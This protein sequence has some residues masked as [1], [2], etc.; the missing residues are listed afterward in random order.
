MVILNKPDSVIN[1]NSRW[2][3]LMNCQHKG[4]LSLS[5]FFSTWPHSP[6]GTGS[7]D[8]LIPAPHRKC[9]E[10]ESLDLAKELSGPW[11]S[12]N[13][14]SVQ[15][16]PGISWQ[17]A[18]LGHKHHLLPSADPS[19]CRLANTGTVSHSHHIRWKHDMLN[20]EYLASIRG[21]RC[22]LSALD[23]KS[24]AAAFLSSIP[25]WSLWAPPTSQIFSF[26]FWISCSNL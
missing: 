17:R 13:D 26:S 22:G 15:Y 6:G 14:P 21:I 25:A 10:Q 1:L 8:C 4:L 7:P 12:S 11:C 5:L 2:L 9:S 20:A 16:W 3:P 18:H 19:L 24:A 23:G